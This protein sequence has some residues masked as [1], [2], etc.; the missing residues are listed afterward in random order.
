MMIS[1]VV[2]VSFYG[3]KSTI[4]PDANREMQFSESQM[5]AAEALHIMQAGDTRDK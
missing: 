1:I 5:F 4:K 2:M 3:T